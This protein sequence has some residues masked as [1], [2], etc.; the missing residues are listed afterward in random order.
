MLP[1]LPESCMSSELESAVPCE[2]EADRPVGV[3]Y[4]LVR[5][6]AALDQRG[7]FRHLEDRGVLLVHPWAD[8]DRE[9]RRQLNPRWL[10]WVHDRPCHELANEPKQ[11]SSVFGLFVDRPGTAFLAG[12]SPVRFVTAGD[13]CERAQSAL[14]ELYIDVPDG[15]RHVEVLSR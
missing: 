5:L 14:V 1:I 6:L 4:D 13:T 2:G 3:D 10:P 12:P 8:A 9:R 11:G 7:T 15:I